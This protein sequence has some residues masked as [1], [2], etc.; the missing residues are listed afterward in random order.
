LRVGTQ[1]ASLRHTMGYLAEMLR[2]A[3]VRVARF[4]RS[5]PTSPSP[6]D[7]PDAEEVLAESV[8][9]GAL[10]LGGGAYSIETRAGWRA[11]NGR[12]G[13]T[14]YRIGRDVAYLR[15]AASSPPTDEAAQKHVQ[16]YQDVWE[17]VLASDPAARWCLIHDL[18]GLREI[19]R[20]VRGQ[21][22]RGYKSLLP[23][24]RRSVIVVPPAL[25]R[26][27]L[28]F[29]PFYG[30][31]GPTRFSVHGTAV[32]ALRECLGDTPGEALFATADPPEQGDG[33]WLADACAQGDVELAGRRYTVHAPDAWRLSVPGFDV[34][35]ALI[36]DRL[37]VGRFEGE[38]A[39][40][41]GER[42]GEI[43]DLLRTELAGRATMYI[44]DIRGVRGFTLQGIRQTVRVLTPQR[45]SWLPSATH[46]SRPSH[47]VAVRVFQSVLRR[48]RREQFPAD[49][50]RRTA[51]RLLTDGPDELVAPPLSVE[52]YREA[53][54]T[55]I[56]A[57]SRVA[58]DD[59]EP[60]APPP[61]AD[62]LVRDL[63]G[64]LAFVQEDV[65]DLMRSLRA[66]NDALDRKVRE[67]TTDLERAKELA[68]GLAA[69]KQ[70]LL[71]T[72]SHEVRTPLHGISSAAELLRDAPLDAEHQELVRALASSAHHLTSLVNDLLDWS[73]LEGEI[74]TPEASACDLAA[75]VREVTD[76][77]RGGAREKGLALTV[78]VAEGFPAALLANPVRMR[79]VL[80][81][82]VGNAVKF[83]AAGEVSVTL[84]VVDGDR[85]R[86]RVRDTGAGIPAALHDRLFE[87]FSPAAQLTAAR[88]G[89][90]GLGLAI[91]RRIVAQHGGDLTV[92]SDVGQG[93]TFTVTLPLRAAVSSS[94][95]RATHAP[96][97]LAGMRVLLAEDNPTIQLV[98]ARLLRRW[99]ARVTVVDDGAQ[100]LAALARDDFDVVLMDLQMP[101]LDGVSATQQL[102]ARERAEAPRIPV[103]AVTADAT[104]EA[105]SAAREA[106][107][108]AF[109]TK[110]YRPEELYAALAGLRQGA[111]RV[112]QSSSRTP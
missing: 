68:E 41:A 54:S 13:V 66:S 86:T 72:M 107:A 3:A 18:R 49:S 48:E 85:A 26:L 99:N 75:I 47:Q 69:E 112:G 4:E 102:R 91:T 88:F 36:D 100:C 12:G 104:P 31:E 106:G 23:R 44:S 105:R 46:L 39:P 79:Q 76:A 65:R 87:P 30:G 45:L 22:A 84:D 38:A 97:A 10:P 108:D 63:I 15:Y 67:R 61:W 29:A 32:A 28:T 21:G 34:R 78:A 52:R 83:T 64:M 6:L 20:G 110:P 8:R 33:A 14:A 90:T 59:D 27:A 2:A 42:L 35:F 101:V 70:R 94:D 56:L 71:S 19:P 93:S 11:V 103:V 89:G 96:D 82:L 109:I 7:G 98:A 25:E 111:S 16:A 62:P 40:S 17:A 92:E 43:F 74:H 95:A 80:Y 73:R 24:L 77:L 9:S 53:I 57:L 51:A 81:N 58:V 5:T 1:L 60:I 55:M 50:L 37:L